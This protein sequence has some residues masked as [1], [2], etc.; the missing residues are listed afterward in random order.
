MYAVRLTVR[1]ANTL[2]NYYYYYYTRNYY[3]YSH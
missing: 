3:N 2:R 1:G